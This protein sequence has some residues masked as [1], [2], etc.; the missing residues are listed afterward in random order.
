[1]KLV[2]Q[3]SFWRTVLMIW[4]VVLITQVFFLVFAYYYL[5]LPG[6]QQTAHVVML[7][8]DTIEAS[9]DIIG[10]D[11][12]I[13]AL[14]KHENIYITDDETQ[15]AIAD[16]VDFAGRF[17]AP[18]RDVLGPETE[19]RVGS[20]PR[21]G[22]WITHPK[23][24]G[25]WIHY[26][27]QN[28]GQYEGWIVLIW[29]VG[30]PLFAFVI[31]ALFVRQLNRPL[32]RLA[33][34]ATR[35]GRGEPV[36]N[37]NIESGPREI[38]AV[39]QAFNQMRKSLQEA[40][41]ERALLLAGISHDLRTPLTRMRLT[42]ELLGA[43]DPELTEGMVRDIEDMDAILDQ[44]IAFIR[45]GNDEDTEVGDLNEV[46]QEV[47]SQYHA[48]GVDLTY[49]LK[50][51]PEISLKRLSLKRMFMNLIGNAVRHGGGKID[52]ESGLKDG[53]ILV[54]VADRGPGLTEEEMYAL[55]QPFARGDE[56]RSTQGSGL[57]LAIVK[58]IV[59]MHHG[60]V[61]LENREGGGLVALVYLPVTG[62]LV[63]PDS[64]LSGIR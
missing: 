31:A 53:E 3:S 40:T 58:R 41:R 44:F 15:V 64:M 2:P 57:G 47:V 16:N 9:A 54:T 35:T 36:A 60:R 59:D 42:A 10:R 32:K 61:T 20:S 24:Q 18:M 55:F 62:Q 63:P 49:S 21:P 4:L 13:E 27:L 1:M 30:T 6:V 43:T 14:S 52:V 17:F 51:L 29:S 39:N 11:K 38:I 37:L 5:F 56:S 28:W 25:M 12:V 45:D 48:D 7:E 46:I 34:A 33:T 8:I 19:L 22:L 50:E 26:P 23:L